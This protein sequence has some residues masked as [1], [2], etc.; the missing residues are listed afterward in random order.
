MG[1]TVWHVLL[2]MSVIVNGGL[3]VGASVNG[4]KTEFVLSGLGLAATAAA[5]LA[6]R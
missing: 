6:S 4:S 2:V 1:P 3:F 5:I